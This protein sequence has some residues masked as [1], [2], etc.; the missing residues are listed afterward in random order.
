LRSGAFAVTKLSTIARD[1]IAPAGFELLPEP[2][3]R[4]ERQAVSGFSSWKKRAKNGGDGDGRTVSETDLL[5][6]V[7]CYAANGQNAKLFH[8]RNSKRV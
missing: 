3:L 7:H 8:E 1:L 6:F 2:A 5:H 4:K